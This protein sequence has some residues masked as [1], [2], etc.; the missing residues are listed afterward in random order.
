MKT[1]I[2]I[3]IIS[4]VLLLLAS[5]LIISCT[6]KD[7]YPQKEIK[8]IENDLEDITEEV[9]NQNQQTEEST[10]IYI[11]H[12]KLTQT[13]INE[14]EQIYGITPPEGEYWYDSQSGLQGRWG[15]QAAGPIYPGHDFGELPREASNGH[16]SI[17][18]NGRELPESE[19]VFLE[20]L[21]QI[22][23]IPGE[24]WL[25]GYGNIGFAGQLPFANLYAV[26]SSQSSPSD[27]GNIWSSYLTGAGG[28]SAGGCSY[29]NLPSGSGVSAGFV[30]TGCG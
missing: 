5:F 23:R 13:Q 14:L 30:S 26:L 17:I 8:K 22:Q 6:K 18:I 4:I 12:K 9:T 24:Y 3:S 11:N 1:K 25:D 19:V 27:G 15:E 28:G 16:T 7:T 2:L 21:L 20:L 10:A 29:V